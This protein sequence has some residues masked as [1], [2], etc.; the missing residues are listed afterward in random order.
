MHANGYAKI[1]LKSWL[2]EI[3]HACENGF[4]VKAA[5]HD[6]FQKYEIPEDLFHEWKKNLVFRK[7][8][9]N[10]PRGRRN[11]KQKVDFG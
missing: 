10:P 6:C 4:T 1:L 11:E 7:F 9:T 2:R 3:N 8:L 5:C